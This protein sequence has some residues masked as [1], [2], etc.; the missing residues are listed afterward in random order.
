M[1][2]RMTVRSNPKLLIVPLVVVVLFALALTGFAVSPA[3][4]IIGL[5]VAGYIAFILG[6]F[7]QKQ[8]RCVVEV[9]EEGLSLD[10]Y[11]EEKVE[12]SWEEVTHLGTAREHGRRRQLFLYREEVDKLLVV[13]D[14]FERFDALVAEVAPHGDMLELE[15]EQNETLKVRLRLIVGGDEPEPAPSDSG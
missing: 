14:E 15:L 13:P 3:L 2:Y 8:L 7:V 12:V 4:G 5:V 6:R 9:R 10:L 1:T 11:G